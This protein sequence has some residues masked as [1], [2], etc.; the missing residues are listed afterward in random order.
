MAKVPKT[1]EQDAGGGEEE[2]D[3]SVFAGA[4]R[5]SQRTANANQANVIS[6]WRALC[7]QQTT[8][9]YSNMSPHMAETFLKIAE[10]CSA[11][12]ET[13]WLEE[14]SKGVCEF[15]L[16]GS[17]PARVKTR[18]KGPLVSKRACK[19]FAGEAAKVSNVEKRK[20]KESSSA[21]SSIPEFAG[22]NGPG[23]PS[24]VKPGVSLSISQQNKVKALQEKRNAKR[25]Q[26][27]EKHKE[28]RTTKRPKK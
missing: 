12:M 14:K 15:N 17:K 10:Q 6:R 24:K 1:N 7:K 5:S 13:V 19:A 27:E 25:K 8:W 22:V 9:T 23:R 28:G 21:G 20:R 16:E 11:D 4:E 2:G 3:C 26:A 18:V